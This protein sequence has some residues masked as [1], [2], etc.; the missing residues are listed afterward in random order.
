MFHSSQTNSALRCYHQ[1]GPPLALPLVFEFGQYSDGMTIRR[2]RVFNRGVELNP[3]DKLVPNA[4]SLE[5]SPGTGSSHQPASGR[6]DFASVRAMRSWGRFG[7]AMLGTT[8]A[9]SR[10]SVSLKRGSGDSAVR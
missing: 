7:P 5:K 3:D 10:A 1:R 9:K 8:S 2:P 6:S 4:E